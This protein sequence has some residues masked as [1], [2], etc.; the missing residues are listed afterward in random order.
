MT[1]AI[2]YVSFGMITVDSK[3]QYT[4]HWWLIL[5]YVVAILTMTSLAGWLFQSG[6][7]VAAG[8]TIVLL[9]LVY[10]FFGLRW[11]VNKAAAANTN[12]T[13]AGSCSGSETTSGNKSSIPI[14]NMCPDFMVTWTD[15]ITGNVYCYDDKN[16]YNMRTYNGAGL[17]TGLSINNVAGQSAYLIKNNTQNTSAIDLKSDTGGLR[18]PF[19]RM[20]G[21]NI[22]TMT[23]DQYGAFLRWE[24]VWD[25]STLSLGSAPLP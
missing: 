11:F 10:V 16:T 2:N 18:W 8:L 22:D 4:F 12:S 9:L 13:T 7:P 19:L 3:K 24:G 14:V 25:G 1:A 17:T 20:L 23:N 5:Y 6:R 21:N 15:S